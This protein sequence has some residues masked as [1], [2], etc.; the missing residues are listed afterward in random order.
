MTGIA[1]GGVLP[2][3]FSMLSD[4]VDTGKRTEASGALGIAIGMGLGIGQVTTW[5]P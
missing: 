3:L 2:V 4:L 1:I 5:A